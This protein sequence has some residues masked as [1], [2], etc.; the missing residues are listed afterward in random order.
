MNDL[1]EMTLHAVWSGHHSIV[2][3]V[4]SL[5]VGSAME[6]DLMCAAWREMECLAMKIIA[7]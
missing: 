4:G 7:H 1:V 6:A 5:M 3:K 2:P